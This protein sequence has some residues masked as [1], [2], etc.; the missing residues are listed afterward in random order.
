MSKRIILGALLTDRCKEAPAFQEVITQFGCNIKTRIGLH[1]VAETSCSTAGLILLEM[2]GDEERLNQ[3]E[4]IIRHMEGILVQK[5]VF[6][7][8]P[9]AHEHV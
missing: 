4:D 6:E 9:T 5:M 3:L 1:N 7:E 2:F 8:P